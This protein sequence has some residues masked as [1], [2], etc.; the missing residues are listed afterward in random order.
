ME[1][2]HIFD[3]VAGTSTGGLIAIMLG[4]LGMNITE[5]IEA[6]GK[7]SKKIFGK[8]HVRGII[9]GGLAPSKYSGLVLLPHWF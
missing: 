7:L 1:P 6:Y 3:L 4:K 9:T 8:K 5:C 2:H